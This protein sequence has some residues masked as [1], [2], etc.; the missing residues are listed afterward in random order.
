MIAASNWRS[1]RHYFQ[2]RCASD[3]I[4]MKIGTR[5]EGREA[6]HPDIDV[7]TVPEQGYA[8]GDEMLCPKEQHCH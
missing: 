7:R 4:I 8:H 3:A 2:N 5:V 1:Q 6:F